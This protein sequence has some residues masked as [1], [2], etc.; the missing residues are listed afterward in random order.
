M[1][2]I[3]NFIDIINKEKVNVKVWL[4]IYGVV[5]DDEKMEELCRG[6]QAACDSKNIQLDIPEW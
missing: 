1:K 5:D 3:I 6:V 2:D 4:N